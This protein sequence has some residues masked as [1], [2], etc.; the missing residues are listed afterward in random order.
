MRRG[1]CVVQQGNS[2]PFGLP[3]GSPPPPP[4]PG[5]S[6]SAS[7]SRELGLGSSY[8]RRRVV[9]FCVRRIS[10]SSVSSDFLHVVT[11]G[12]TSFIFEGKTCLYMPLFLRQFVRPRGDVKSAVRLTCRWVSNSR[13]FFFLFFTVSKEWRFRP[14]PQTVPGERSLSPPPSPP[15][16]PESLSAWTPGH[17]CGGALAPG[18]AACFS[19][20]FP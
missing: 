9:S 4:Q 19:V 12:R 7:S 6:P 10:L 5:S 2:V 13:I 8:T 18:P 20:I 1:L 17:P 14:G 11:N 15:L 3:R 16:R